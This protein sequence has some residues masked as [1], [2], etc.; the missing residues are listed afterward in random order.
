MNISQLDINRGVFEHFML[1][2]IMQVPN[3]IKMTIEEFKQFISAG[4]ESWK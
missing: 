4:V 2:E 1:K 3:A